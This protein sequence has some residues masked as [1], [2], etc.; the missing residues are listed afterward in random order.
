[1]SKSNIVF[2]AHRL[3]F[4]LFSII[5]LSAHVLGQMNTNMNLRHCMLTMENYYTQGAATPSEVSISG[6]GSFSVQH[7]YSY[8]KDAE[9]NLQALCVKNL[10][11]GTAPSTKASKKP[12]TLANE[13]IKLVPNPAQDEITVEGAWTSSVYFFD[14]FG[15]QMHFV[16]L[17]TD[18]KIDIS[19]LPCG[20]YTVKI[21]RQGVVYTLPLL[22]QR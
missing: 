9:G 3:V 8:Y 2:A 20:I 10:V 7:E 16:R 14:C 21:D 15:R 18:L 17:G 5:V 1:M 19:S 12:K 6:T 22:I 11:E 4:T 13:K